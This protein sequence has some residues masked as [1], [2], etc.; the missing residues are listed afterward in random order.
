M[1]LLH[2]R[3]LLDN[4]REVIISRGGGG[5]GSKSAAASSSPAIQASFDCAKASTRVEKMIC[6]DAALAELD[7]TLAARYA[8]V[9]QMGDD[10]TYWKQDQRKWV[11]ERNQCQ[12]PS[13][14]VH[15]YNVRIQDLEQ[16]LQY[17][18]KP[19]EYR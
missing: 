3:S 8:S 1:R 9:L 14:L 4:E 6:S 13:C 18:N 19:A 5:A 11:K 15:S 10:K 12:Q 2:V 17:L 16:V 7:T